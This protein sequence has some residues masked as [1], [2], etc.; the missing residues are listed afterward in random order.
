M[1]DAISRAEHNEFMKRI[2]EENYRQ[3][4]RL[5]ALEKSIESFGRIAGSVD[6]LAGNMQ[7][8]TDELA[9]QGVRIEQIERRPGDNWNTI[10]KSVLTGIGSSIAA[11]SIAIFAISNFIK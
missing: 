2:E 9:R 3:N 7:N 4:K 11:A 8:M 10:I 1:D 5:D 6:R